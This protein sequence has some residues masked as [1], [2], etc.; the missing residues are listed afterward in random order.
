MKIISR[1]GVT[2][3]ISNGFVRPKKDIKTSNGLVFSGSK[4]LLLTTNQGSYVKFCSAF[5]FLDAVK[6]YCINERVNL[7]DWYKVL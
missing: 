2:A 7:Q 6:H 1:R 3:T 4:Y 5:N